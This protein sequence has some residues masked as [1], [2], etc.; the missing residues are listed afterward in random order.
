V[1]V[2]YG[3]GD[4]RAAPKLIHTPGHPP[5]NSLEVRIQYNPPVNILMALGQQGFPVQLRDGF[6]KHRPRL[7]DP[8]RQ[9]CEQVLNLWRRD[10]HHT[11]TMIRLT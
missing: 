9:R 11:Q 5:T 7:I 8:R 1:I 4:E 2:N 6:E 3:M 10:S